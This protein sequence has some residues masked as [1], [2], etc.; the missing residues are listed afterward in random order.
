M[1]KL[2]NI[3]LLF[4]LVFGRLTYVVLAILIAALFFLINWWIANF[5]FLH[6]VLT[7]GVFNLFD[8]WRLFFDFSNLI[9]INFSVLS[10]VTVVTLSLL[11]GINGAS[12]I[13]FIRRK[14]VISSRSSAS[15]GASLISLVGIGCLSCGSVILSSIFGL[16]IAGAIIGVLPFDGYEFAIIGVIL[17]ATSIYLL[18]QKINNNF[19]CKI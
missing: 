12:L 4:I 17:L 13:Y 18:A 16:T 15:F 6:Y 3:R 2:N 1:D 14:L 11:F 19:V 5:G 10:L 7:A 9:D 8:K